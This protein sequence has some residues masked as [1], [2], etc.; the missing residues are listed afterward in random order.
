[1]RKN[2]HWSPESDISEDAVI[3]MMGN[4]MQHYYDAKDYCEADNNQHCLDF[5]NA[6]YILE[7]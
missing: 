2:V 3:F 7:E 4:L 1:M 5:R 6:T